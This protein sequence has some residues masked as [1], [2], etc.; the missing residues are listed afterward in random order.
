MSV[1]NIS[2]R[3]F[4]GIY[5]QNTIMAFQKALEEGV[6]YIELDVSLSKDDHIV[7]FHDSEVSR[8]TDGSGYI[9]DLTLAQ[10][11]ALDSGI[12]TSER[13]RGT[14]IPTLE[15]VLKALQETD[16]KLCIEIKAREEDNVE[17]V[18][19]AVVDL[20]RQ[21][22][23]LDR[24]MFTSYNQ[25]V[26]KNLA[27]LFPNMMIGLDPSEEESETQSAEYIV[28]L[29][30]ECDASVLYFDYL[31]LTQEITDLAHSKGLQVHAWTADDADNI[32]RLI[33][34]GVE[35]VLTNRPDILNE[36]MRK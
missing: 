13:F 31:L 2:H 6:D 22:G 16:A 32:N 8:L 11:L 14:R 20:V 36:I 23:Y 5:P 29:C 7:V 21:Y 28:D 1:L 9:K 10:I 35:A 3:G 26:V 15:E 33:K 25:Q 27:K 12:K 24:V 30:L 34:M 4:S 17:G 19:K 18:D